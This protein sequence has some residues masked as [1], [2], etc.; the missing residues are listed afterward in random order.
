MIVQTPYINNDFID[1]TIKPHITIKARK[2]L[3]ANVEDSSCQ[4]GARGGD[5]VILDEAGLLEP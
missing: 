3:T 4:D 5:T 2:E 1:R